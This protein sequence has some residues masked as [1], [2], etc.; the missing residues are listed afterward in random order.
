ML[1]ANFNYKTS[2]VKIITRDN[3]MYINWSLF[4]TTGYKLIETAT[5]HVVAFY[6][7]SK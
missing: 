6:D 5:A 7:L 1:C 4:T 3:N 2:H